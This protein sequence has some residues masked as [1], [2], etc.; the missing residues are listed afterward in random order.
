LLE[1]YSQAKQ[2]VKAISICEQGTAAIDEKIEQ[3]RQARNIVVKKMDALSKKLGV[4]FQ[5][6]MRRC[7]GCYFETIRQSATHIHIH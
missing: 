1:H 3:K 5:N 7:N 4:K 6:Q 2:Y